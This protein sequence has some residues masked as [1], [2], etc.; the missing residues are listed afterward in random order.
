[1]PF[2]G[3]FLRMEIPGNF[4]NNIGNPTT[5]TLKMAD[6]IQVRLWPGLN[7][8]RIREL[9]RRIVNGIILRSA[10]RFLLFLQ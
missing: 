8:G 2:C 3:Q 7:D 1:M 10:L 4:S 6:L 5:F 9:Q